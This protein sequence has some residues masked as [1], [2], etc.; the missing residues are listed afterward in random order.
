[1][2]KKEREVIV[3]DM[4][5]RFVK[6]SFD[7]VCAFL[8]LC[9]TSPLWLILAIGIKLSSKG[10]VLY[11]SVRIGRGRKPFTLYKFRSMHVYQPVDPS[12]GQTREGGFIANENRIFP[13][14]R[15]LRKSKLDEL[16]Q[17]LNILLGQ[18]SI[19]GPRPLPEGAA[20]R[21]YSGERECVLSVR[22][23]LTCLDSLYDY[24]HGELFVHS[25]EEYR[26]NVLPIRNE[27]AKMYIEKKSVWLDMACIFRTVKLMY[28]IAVLKKKDFP[29]NK[30][31]HE[32]HLKVFEVAGDVHS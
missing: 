26:A 15:F 5:Y 2:T 32:A 11:C 24:A 10:P 31:E 30:Y 16:P 17:L 12:S 27:L 7:F 6:R 18:M 13:L 1:M 14:G 23:G 21:Y 20:E 9:I 22:P 19:V 25:E 4:L 3:M 8:A 29:Y 28:E